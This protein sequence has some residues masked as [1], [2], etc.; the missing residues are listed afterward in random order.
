MR[1]LIVFAAVVILAAVLIFLPADAEVVYPWNETYIGALE[2]EAW[3]GLALIPDEKS[4]FSFRL[5]VIKDD[6]I[7]DKLDLFFLV[8]EVGP[9]SPDGGYARMA[10]DMSLPFLPEE[11]RNETPVLKKPADKSDT[12]VMEWSRTDEQTV[13]GR[14]TAPKYVEVEVVHYFPWDLT[15][16]FQLL[17]DGQ[18][19]GES[20]TVKNHHYLFWTHREDWSSP[21]GTG[22]EVV[23]SFS[24]EKE[25]EI[26][27]VA[28][29][30]ESVQIL[31]SHTQRYK[32]KRIIA[33][34]LKDEE[35]RYEQ[36]RVRVQ[37]LFEGVSRAVTNNLFWMTLYQPGKH[38]LYTPPGR[39]W[40]F[41]RPSG[42]KDH[43]TIFGWDSF[44][45]ALLLSVESAEY[46]R[47]VIHS[48][49]QTQYENGN[50]P[51]W[52]GRFSGT[53]DR[54]QPPVGSYCVL[55]IF[56]KTGDMD[57]LRY[58]YPYLKKWHAFWKAPKDGRFRRDGN[59]D[60]LLEWGS[61]ADLVPENVPPWEEG[62][63]GRQRAMWESGQDD[64]PN[65]DEARF[66]ESTETFTM[67]CVDLNSLYALD[68]YCL[69]Q[70]ANILK[71]RPDYQIYMREYSR[72]KELINEKLWDETEGF[73]FDRHWD[74]T[75]SYRK[76]ASNFY[77]LIAG[78]P[79][80]D[81]AD[82]ML[83]RLLD[84]KEFWGEYV[85]PTIS[86]DDPAFS[87]PSQQYWRGTI[88]PPTNYLV[89]QGL[90]N[91]GYD[92]VA[93]EFAA[94]SA[95]LFMRSWENFQLCPENYDSR[96]GEAEGQRYQSWGPLFA[97]IALEEYIDITPWEG[98][99]F[100]ILYPEDKGEVERIAIQG[101]HYDVKITRRNITLSEEGKKILNI[102]GGAVFRHFLYSKNRV[103]FKVK[104]QDSRKI[105]IWFLTKGK[106]QLLIDGQPR[107][108]FKGN[109][110]KFDV[111]PVESEVVIL[112]LDQRDD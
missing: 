19:E 70:I 26:Y 61:D 46:S 50:I 111:D 1:T 68:A 80:N 67:N 63:P 37:G 102:N 30:N 31:Q 95:A 96:T 74:G 54:S 109:S 43:W 88:W 13:V 24:P 14:I 47:D 18:V 72:M 65:W 41:P 32:N 81:R 106:H 103:S 21:A 86:R 78:I 55:K 17:N 40:I 59:Q 35:K 42:G 8:S 53:P 45:N 76:A 22:Q 51:N 2:A 90:K 98:F 107:K 25:K 12:L 38:R 29:V 62:V 93:S 104:T 97:L 77:P 64:L 112:L 60:G 10:F 28:G 6:R 48:V 83:A 39:R 16:R 89:Y 105:K 73:Y 99:R 69:A 4:A 92:A 108:I 9:N 82:R 20:L 34:V 94:R 101:R 3:A 58:A 7:A 75:F 110:V 57:M 71:N 27:F 23:L 33:S 49:L 15:G 52:R 79:D 44:F 5:R 100:G 84:G 66:S 56:Q 91:Y 87:Q 11:E 36:R 85:I